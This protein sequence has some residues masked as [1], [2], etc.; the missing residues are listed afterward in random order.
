MR[1]N[2]AMDFASDANIQNMKRDVEHV[3]LIILCMFDWC[4][5]HLL[6]DSACVNEIKTISSYDIESY[7]LSLILVVTI[8]WPNNWFV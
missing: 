1:T 8:P 2:A 5:T 3:G 6:L 7:T 4:Y